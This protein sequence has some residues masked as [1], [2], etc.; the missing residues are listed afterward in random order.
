MSRIIHARQRADR[1]LYR[2]WCT[3]PDAYS[4][5]ELSEADMRLYLLDDESPRAGR[6][7]AAKREIDERLTRAREAGSS[8]YSGDKADVRGPWETERCGECG[9]F[10]HDFDG[11]AGLACN[12]CGE[13][14]AE[15]WH[16]PACGVLK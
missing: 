6:S 13:A 5:P 12:H 1:W 15:P 8:A 9:G 10:H 2:E 3:I 11:V 14:Q 7:G 4:T 16:G